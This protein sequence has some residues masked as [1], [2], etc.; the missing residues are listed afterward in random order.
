VLAWLLSHGIRPMLGG[1]RVDQLDS[2]LDGVAL[3]LTD[4]QRDRLDTADRYAW[5][6]PYPQV[7]VPS[8]EVAEPVELPA[9]GRPA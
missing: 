9:T 2:A 1:S 6:N 4:G 5:A 3:R 7:Q 8:A